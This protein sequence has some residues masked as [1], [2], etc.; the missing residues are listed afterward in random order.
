LRESDLT[1][2]LKKLRPE[3]IKEILGSQTRQESPPKPAEQA[4]EPPELVKLQ[5]NCPCLVTGAVF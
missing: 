3:K 4:K 5:K 1:E 2:A